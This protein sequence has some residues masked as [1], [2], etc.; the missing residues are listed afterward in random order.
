MKPVSKVIEAAVG[1]LRK[2]QK[3]GCVD[4]YMIRIPN[5]SVFLPAD[6]PLGSVLYVQ[7]VSSLS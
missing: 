6:A 7:D 1:V 4:D 3:V 5:R 2:T